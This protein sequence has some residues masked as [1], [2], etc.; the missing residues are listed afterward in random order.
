[1]SNKIKEKGVDAMKSYELNFKYGLK[2]YITD[3]YIKHTALAKKATIKADVFSKILNTRRG[4][5]V[6]EAM[7]ICVALGVTIEDIIN[8]FPDK[9][10]V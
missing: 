9:T 5:S 3:K 10:S 4:I 2:A 6:E 7:K 1:M 8:Y